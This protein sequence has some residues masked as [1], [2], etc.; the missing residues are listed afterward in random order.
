MAMRKLLDDG[1]VF[2]GDY[3]PGG[4]PTVPPTAR[5]TSPAAIA[6]NLFAPTEQ[7]TVP[8]LPVTTTPPAATAMPRPTGVVTTYAGGRESGPG[9]NSAG[10]VGSPIPPYPTEGGTT[11]RAAAIAQIYRT[12]LGRQDQAITNDPGYWQWVNGSI[13]LA[14]IQQMIYNS[15]EAKDY[16]TKRTTSGAGGAGGGNPDA[17]GYATQYGISNEDAAY[18]LGKISQYDLDPAEIPYWMEFVQKHGSVAQTGDAWLDDAI[19]RANSSRDVLNGTISRRAEGGGGG[20]STGAGGFAGMENSAAM[21]ALLQDALS[22]I[23]GLGGLS[24]SGADL[25]ASLKKIIDAGGATPDITAQIVKARDNSALAQQGM[26]ADARG[27]M[28]DRGILSEPGVPQGAEMS[29][30]RRIAERIAPEFANS[31]TDI[32]THAMDK[33]QES[34]LSALQ[35][36]TG[37]STD[38]AHNMLQAVTVGTNRQSAIASIALQTLDQNRQWQQF[39]MQHNLDR[40]RLTMEMDQGN[41]QMVMSLIQQFLSAS[42]IGGQGR[43]G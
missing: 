11:G 17:A 22:K 40:D 29:A 28:A 8:R 41:W 23:I 35:M 30:I 2:S 24:D 21:D 32:Q 26:L 39:L 18:V 9:S 31:L 13:P 36:A 14:D 4:S 25:S 12:A 42:A 3:L 38:A 7:P 33:G 27:E 20:G 15:Q 6:P 34:L 1:S 5:A 43:I 19:H 16:G 10:G 37:L